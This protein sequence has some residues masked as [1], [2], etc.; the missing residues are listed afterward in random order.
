M[1]MKDQMEKRGKLSQ[2]GI[3]PNMA[4]RKSVS[5]LRKLGLPVKR[6][7]EEKKKERREEKKKKKE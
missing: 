5:W 1:K 4:L 7:E 3:R 6:R 2:I